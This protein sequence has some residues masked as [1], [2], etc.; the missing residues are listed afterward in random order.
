MSGQLKKSSHCLR[1][2]KLIWLVGYYFSLD[3]MAEHPKSKSTGGCYHPEVSPC[4]TKY[5]RETCYFGG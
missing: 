5:L 2:G 3:R 4:K 1:F